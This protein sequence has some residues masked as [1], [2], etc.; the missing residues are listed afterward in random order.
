MA[1][2]CGK[3]KAAAANKPKTITVAYPD[4]TKKSYSS[5]T[6]ARVAAARGAGRILVNG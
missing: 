1:C 4:G 2:A 6:E 5:D 3:G